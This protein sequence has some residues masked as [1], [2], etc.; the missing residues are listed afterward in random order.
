MFAEEGYELF[1]CEK[2]KEDHVTICLL[3]VEGKISDTVAD[4]VVRFGIGY[5][6]IKA[7]PLN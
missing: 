3:H 1:Q 6:T 4:S 7:L 5:A 2:V